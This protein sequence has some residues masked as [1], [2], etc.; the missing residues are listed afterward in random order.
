MR[1]KH[2]EPHAEPQVYGWAFLATRK[3]GLKFYLDKD[4]F[5]CNVIKIEFFIGNHEQAC[6]E[7]DR[8]GLEFGRLF[9]ESLKEVVFQKTPE[10]DPKKL[11]ALK[12]YLA[13]YIKKQ[14]NEQL[15]RLNIS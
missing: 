13:K 15:R 5:S 10:T 3:N 7:A 8:R 12:I 6:K 4:G 1:I 2:P 9:S 14:S 11:E